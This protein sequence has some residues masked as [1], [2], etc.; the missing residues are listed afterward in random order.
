MGDRI[1]GCTVCDWRGYRSLAHEHHIIPQAA[2]GTDDPTNLVMLCATCHHALHMIGLDI[3]N[4]KTN[5]A[6]DRLALQWPEPARREQ[7][8]HLANTVAEEFAEKRRKGPPEEHMVQLMLDHD[9][10]AHLKLLAQKHPGKPGVARFIK[11][12]LA[13]LVERTRPN[14][15]K[16]PAGK[17]PAKRAL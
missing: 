7:A 2:G 8:T 17:R 9:T 14:A 3:L 6:R 13:A 12:Q 16:G 5:R 1:V 4:G 10:F 15:P 11:M